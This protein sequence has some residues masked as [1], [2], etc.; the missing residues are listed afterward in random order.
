MSEEL[1]QDIRA[2][3]TDSWQIGRKVPL[4]LDMSSF[5][6]NNEVSLRSAWQGMA[7]KSQLDLGKLD[8]RVQIDTAEA[9]L[10][11]K[12]TFPYSRHSSYPELCDLVKLFKPRDIYPCTVNPVQ[13]RN[14]GQCCYSKYDIMHMLTALGISIGGLFGDYCSGDEFLFDQSFWHPMSVLSQAQVNEDT[15]ST[16]SSP[17]ASVWNTQKTVDDPD[18]M[19][20]GDGEAPGGPGQPD[21]QSVAHEL[22]L[23]PA[24]VYIQ[25]SQDSELSEEVV[26]TRLQAF[27]AVLGNATRNLGHEIGLLSTRDHHTEMEQDLGED[28]P[29]C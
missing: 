25:S 6:D 21:S 3:L 15:Q 17:D 10:P 14:E 23:D 24:T 16:T 8:S 22:M 26:D 13:W 1:Q 28:Q 2:M 20:E 19:D 4:D 18:M 7:K 29:N 27:R 9:D 11:N 12:I 5:G